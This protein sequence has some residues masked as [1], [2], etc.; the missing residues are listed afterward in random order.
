MAN[1]MAMCYEIGGGA[2]AQYN[3]AEAKTHLSELIEL[4]VSGDEVVIAR[5]GRP[6]ARL[7]AIGAAA[8]P[9]R[10][11]FARDLG[12]I[13][14]SDDFDAPLDDFAEYMP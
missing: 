14:M 2:M 7:V 6:I 13:T 3:V 9:R 10:V 1:Q 8:G 11:G 4:A 5:A 12:P